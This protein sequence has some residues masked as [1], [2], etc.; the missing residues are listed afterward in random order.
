MKKKILA[1]CL[2]VVLAIT[3]VTG[4]TLAYFTDTEDE[5]ANAKPTLSFWAAAIQS[6]HLTTNSE[7]FAFS[8][9]TWPE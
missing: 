5:I 1:L 3:A 4:A 6:E 9:I 2:V 7:G 8:Q